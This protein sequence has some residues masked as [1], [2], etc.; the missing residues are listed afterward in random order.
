MKAVLKISAAL[1][2]LVLVV[3]LGALTWLTLRK[4]AQRPPSTE[5]VERTPERVARGEYIVHHLAGCLGCHSDYIADRYGMPLKP[6]TEGQG[7]YVFDEKV[8]FPGTVCAQNITP[9]AETGV[10]AWTDGELMRAIREGVA[11]NGRALFP[12][13][14]YTYYRAM[15][16]EDVK[17][18]VAYLRALQPIKHQVPLGKIKFPV[19]LMIKF[20]PKPLEGPVT[21]PGDASDHLG[22]G[23]Y[24]VTV[25]GCMECHTQHDDKGQLVPGR[26]F[27]GGFVMEGP[28]GKVVSANLTPHP[29][30]FMGQA[31]KEAFVARIKAFAGMGADDV[32]V[33]D[34]G[35]NTIMPWRDFAGLTVKDLEA[36]YDYLKT[37]KPIENKIVPFPDARDAKG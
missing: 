3:V 31:T 32:P 9:D 20:V 6:G 18:V 21:A 13:M 25:G 19:N 4:P 11:K 29:D 12:M 14:P 2:A 15:S 10:G 28:W 37:L 17:S 33:A 22:Y 35:R 16:D 7:G 34:P 24:L 36:I 8:G 1:V 26:E 30:T 23:K 27:A 5:V